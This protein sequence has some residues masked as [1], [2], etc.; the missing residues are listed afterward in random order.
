M[1]EQGTTAPLPRPELSPEECEWIELLVTSK[2]GD[3][4]RRVSGLAP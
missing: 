2:P 3:W 1:E 4:I